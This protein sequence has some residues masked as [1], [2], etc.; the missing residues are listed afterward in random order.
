MAAKAAEMAA[1][2]ASDESESDRAI[3]AFGFAIAAARNADRDDVERRIWAAASDW[4]AK[5]RPWWK[6]W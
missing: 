6:F 1:R 5:D 2:A 4:L 3:E